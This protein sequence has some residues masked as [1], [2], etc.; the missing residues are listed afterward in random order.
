VLVR[1]LVD[2]HSAAAVRLMILDRPW[3][4]DWDY[5]PALLDRAEE[6]LEQLYQAAGRT[7]QAPAAAAET[8]RLLAADLNAPAAVDVAIEEGGAAARSVTA[9]LGLN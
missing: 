4:E 7:R 8:G 5:S 6:R 2:G 9:V 3:S 1:D